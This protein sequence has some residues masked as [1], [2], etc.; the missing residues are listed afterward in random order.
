VQTELSQYPT[1]F[2][3]CTWDGGW[4]FDAPCVLYYPVVRFGIG[5]NS[6]AIDGLVE[7]YCFDLEE[8][9]KPPRVRAGD[10]QEFKWRGYSQ[11][12]FKHRKR[13]WHVEIK[14]RW[15]RDSHGQPLFELLDRREGYGP[16]AAG[17]RV[18]GS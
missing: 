6:G 5:G 18:E 11:R 7:D 17:P 14:V 13:A 1:I 8:G 16:L 2:R 3:G 12:G 10:L 9:K 15:T 4:E